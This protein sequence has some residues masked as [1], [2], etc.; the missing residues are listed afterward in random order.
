MEYISLE[1]LEFAAFNRGL[2]VWSRNI[3][4]PVL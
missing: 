3:F 2:V 4:I 1:W